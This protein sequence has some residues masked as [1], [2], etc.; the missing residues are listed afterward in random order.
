[1]ASFEPGVDLCAAAA[2]DF[3]SLR[4]GALRHDPRT[5]PGVAAPHGGHAGLETEAMYHVEMLN[6]TMRNERFAAAAAAA[7]RWAADAAEAPVVSLEIGAGGTALL[8]LAAARAGAGA[9]IAVESEPDLAR[10]SRAV[11]ADN[12]LSVQVFEADSLDLDAAFVSETL[13]GGANVVLAELFDDRL[14]GERVL[15]TLRH[16]VDHLAAPAPAVV[17]QRAAVYAA[18]V[19]SDT[20]ALMSRPPA[21]GSALVHA[22]LDDT[23]EPM[24][25]RA[26][27]DLDYVSSAWA[28]LN[29]DLC[30]PKLKGRRTVSVR[31][32]ASSDDGDEGAVR[33]D[34]VAFWWRAVLW[35]CPETGEKIEVSSADARSHWKQCV[36][37][38]DEPLFVR[39]GGRVR[40]TAA[41]NDETVG[42]DVEACED[43]DAGDDVRIVDD[44]G[45]EE[46]DEEDEEEE[47]DEEE[48]TEEGSDAGSFC[49]G[50]CESE[51]PRRW[52]LA[53]PER[54]AAI[55][56]AVSG[57]ARGAGV[58][59]S[60]CGGSGLCLE[61]VRAAGARA[62]IACEWN[63][64]RADAV[65]EAA[66]RS[67]HADATPA[68]V[69]DGAGE[70]ASSLGRA[71]AELSQDLPPSDAQASGQGVEG[72]LKVDALVAEPFFVALGAEVWAKGHALLW[73]WSVH[74]AR[75]ADL[76]S[77]GAAIWPARGT[78]RGK[79][80]NFDGLWDATRT[81]ANAAGFSL[82][83]LFADAEGRPRGDGAADAAPAA[84]RTHAVWEHAHAAC[85]EAFD[86]LTLD[87]TDA[88][89]SN[90][91]GRVDVGACAAGAN[92]VVLWV[93]YEVPGGA[94]LS[95]GPSDRGAPTPWAQGVV[96][97]PAPL[98]P[99]APLTVFAH[100][101]LDPLSGELCV[102]IHGDADEQ[103]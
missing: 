35:E 14:L 46:D 75:Q 56:R 30:D 36:H 89:P 80:V 13:R 1:M 31:V 9:A 64:A 48:A 73:W 97:L 47:D 87:F 16:A 71:L 103:R 86:L 33:V 61:A 53:E 10:R 84:T 76:L 22:A 11:A 62:A 41:H 38:L 91:A 37:F 95:T 12:G 93:D 77:T 8:S 18:L 88:P 20:L 28:V 94:A 15:P 58:A 59:A 65:R 45:D 96:F 52:M 25:L 19:R 44:E 27:Q 21:G 23:V 101:S 54:T 17:P 51:R 4:D 26:L 2:A 63:P 34:A 68:V 55:F 42:F 40:V 67:D 83:Q 32:R 82:A 39:P 5:P 70:L 99:G 24:R 92:A 7:V 60:V 98:A 102:D 3:A 57:A 72:S 6:D 49:D 78:L 43:D 66:L 74:A 85:T 100:A 81:P 90:L 50:G 69:V 79:L 29:F